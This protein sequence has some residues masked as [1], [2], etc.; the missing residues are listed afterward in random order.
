MRNLH[1]LSASL[2]APWHSPISAARPARTASVIFQGQSPVSVLLDELFEVRKG[3]LRSM[4]RAAC[5]GIAVQ[6]KG[7]DPRLHRVFSAAS[8][9]NASACIVKSYDSQG[10]LHILLRLIGHPGTA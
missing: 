10:R 5:F 2:S 9:T 3:F 8:M 7:G 1:G 4:P 6:R